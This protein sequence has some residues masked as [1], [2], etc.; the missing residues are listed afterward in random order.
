MD[1]VALT[2]HSPYVLGTLNNLLY[3]GSI[4]KKYLTMTESVIPE[5]FWVNSDCF[6]AWFVKGGIIENCMDWE[7]HMIQN[8][9]IDEI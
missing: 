1:S 6:D 5:P 8:E 4:P 9:R 7:I 3:A 2:T